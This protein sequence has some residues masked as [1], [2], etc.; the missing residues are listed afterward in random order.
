MH[1]N[2]SFSQQNVNKC[3]IDWKYIVKDKQYSIFQTCW[4]PV[5]HFV[6]R[7]GFS[8][9]CVTKCLQVC[10]RCGII[11]ILKLKENCIFFVIYK[12]CCVCFRINK[13]LHII[14]SSGA[15]IKKSVD[16]TSL[17]LAARTDLPL[18]VYH[19]IIQL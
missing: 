12:A 11:W 10:H 19:L 4:R 2:S 17:Y 13:F 7:T 18:R 8:S 5:D 14:F 6:W 3:S 9:C 1:K 15:F 16:G